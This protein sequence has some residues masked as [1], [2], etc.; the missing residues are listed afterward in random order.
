ML[1]S[2]TIICLCHSLALSVC[3]LAGIDTTMSRAIK[4]IR[5]NI[6]K[7]V[8]PNG[9]IIFSLRLITRAVSIVAIPTIFAAPVLPGEKVMAGLLVER[10]S[11]AA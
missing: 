4:P 11:E 2:R 3:A 10:R 5:R 9:W 8:I 6:S 7:P 1:L